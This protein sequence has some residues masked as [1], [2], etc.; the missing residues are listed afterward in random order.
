MS[1]AAVAI[2]TEVQ[3]LELQLSDSQLIISAGGSS[4]TAP[5]VLSADDAERLRMEMAKAQLWEWNQIEYPKSKAENRYRHYLASWLV[6]CLAAFSAYIGYPG[7]Y[8][9]LFLSALSIFIWWRVGYEEQKTD[10]AAQ[11]ERNRF[12]PDWSYFQQRLEEP[13]AP[14]GG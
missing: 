12:I 9:S 7:Y 13:A 1:E 3:G 10:A 5:V 4:L 6:L 8:L 2:R 14:G 11:A